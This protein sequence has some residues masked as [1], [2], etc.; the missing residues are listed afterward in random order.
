MG[1]SIEANQNNFATEV[2]ERSQQQLVLVDFF[3]QWCGPC[4]VLKPILEKL[5]EEYNFTLAK[6]DI[7]K[8]P[9]LAQAYRVEGVPDVKIF[10]QGQMQPGFVGVLPEAQI[11]ELLAQYGLKS[12]LDTEIEAIQLDRAAGN[13]ETAKQ[14]FR[15]L[16]ELYPQNPKLAIAAA[17]FLIG[18]GS[19]E[20]AEKLLAAVPSGSREY[21]AKVRTLREL[22]QW[23]HQ[24]AQ[25][26]PETDLDQ[27]YLQAAQ[28]TLKGDYESA[29]SI[30]LAMVER[31]RK[32]QN[33][34][35]RK[36]MIT[37]FGLLGDDHP[38]TKS[39]RKQLTLVLY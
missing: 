20:S 38:L 24:A 8:N 6:V 37:I 12:T 27:Q 29:L 33:D 2:I 31:D 34:A 32:Y 28:L 11:R 39:Y 13:I 17:E 15:E 5:V 3:A 35:A 10:S 23:Q 19:L 7:D 16:I 1:R 30:L 22:M 9:E 14:R 36:A 4:Q 21:D 18:I 25:L 26:G